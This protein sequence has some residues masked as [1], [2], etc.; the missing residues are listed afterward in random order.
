MD[1]MTAIYLVIAHFGNMCEVSDR[2]VRAF[3]TKE[4]AERFATTRREDIA[5]L[6]GMGD[7]VNNLMTE[8]YK[9]HKCLECKGEG[10]AC[11]TFCEENNNHL[12]YLQQVTGYEKAHKEHIGH[13]LWENP[14]D[15]GFSVREVPFGA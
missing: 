4:Q 8:W 5:H 9:T 2:P 7:A 3:P 10:C 14:N 12:H 13:N 6:I 1:N 11:P 15:V